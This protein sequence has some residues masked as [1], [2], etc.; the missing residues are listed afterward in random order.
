MQTRIVLLAVFMVSL[1]LATS[2]QKQ[3]AGALDEVF[4]L[5]NDGAEMP[6]FVRGNAAATKVLVIVHGGPG[7]TS[8]QHYYQIPEF[9]Q[10]MEEHHL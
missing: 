9:T 5:K 10:R 8:L 2:C 4:Y 7:S 3:G 1:L 6:V